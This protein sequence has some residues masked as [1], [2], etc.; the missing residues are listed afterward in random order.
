MR[1]ETVA[2][3]RALPATAGERVGLSAYFGPITLAQYATH[4]VDHDM[5]HLSQLGQCRAA[6]APPE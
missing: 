5:E 6:I 4:V 1:A 3:V 2:L